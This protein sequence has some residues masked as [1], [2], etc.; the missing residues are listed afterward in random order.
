M[1]KRRLTQIQR[2]CTQ[3]IFLATCYLLLATFAYAEPVSSTELIRNAKQYDG[4][5]VTYEGEVIGDIMVRGEFAWVNI[6]DGATAIGIWMDKDLA[7]EIVYE[8][9]Y[10]AQG[11]IV[12]VGGTFHRACKEHGGDLDIHGQSLQITQRG[13][14]KKVNVGPSKI[15]AAKFLW[16]ICLV[17]ALVYFILRRR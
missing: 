9:Q 17:S 2:R 11:D 12:L 1:I 4:Q 8:G 10:S 3:I 5:T 15:K 13:F 6:N 7:K 16:A 14:A